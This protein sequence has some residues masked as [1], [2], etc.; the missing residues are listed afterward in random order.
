MYCHR[1]DTTQLLQPYGSSGSSSSGGSSA[2]A[3]SRQAWCQRC[4]SRLML[5]PLCIGDTYSVRAVVAHSSKRNHFIVVICLDIVSNP[6][7]PPPVCCI[8]VQNIIFLIFDRKCKGLASYGVSISMGPLVTVNELWPRVSI[9]LKKMLVTHVNS[10]WAGE[11]II[12]E[13]QYLIWNLLLNSL[14]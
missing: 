1:S 6:V 8:N 7:S 3:L 11:W 5:T 13:M 9:F 10:K 14:N 4:A 12:N 2:D